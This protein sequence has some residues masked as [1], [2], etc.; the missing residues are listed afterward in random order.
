MDAHPPS[1]A[2]AILDDDR[3]ARC[4]ALFRTL[5]DGRRHAYA[6]LAG[7]SSHTVRDD[8]ATLRSLGMSLQLDDASVC[9]APFAVLDAAAIADA[10]GGDAPAWRV[11]VA[12]AVDSTNTALLRD[13]KTRDRDDGPRVLAAEL[14]RAGRGRLGRDWLSAPGAS[15]T[16]S[17][18]IHVARGISQLDGVTLVCG[19]A[20]QRVL[21]TRGV[22]ARLKWPNDVLVEG[23]KLAGILVEVQATPSGTVLVIGI[24]LNIAF[25]TPGLASASALPVA[26]LWEEGAAPVDRNRLVAELGRSLEAHLAAFA[27][28]GFGAFVDAWHA[29]DAFADRAVHLVSPPAPA[30]AGIARGVDVSGALLLEVGGDLR[31]IIAGDVSLRPARA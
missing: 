27:A 19:L 22:P 21:A 24:G 25:A 1:T 28:D 14:Q 29:V 20:V 31:R 8:L 9:A 5:A 6:D 18:A 23:R 17:F 13:A 26:N 16:A 10:L 11:Q 15:I 12:F 2:S 30:V 7:V 4:A 3:D